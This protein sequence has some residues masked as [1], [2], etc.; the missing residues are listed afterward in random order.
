MSG[1]SRH[2]CVTRRKRSHQDVSLFR[3]KPGD[4]LARKPKIGAWSGSS[5]QRTPGA[6]DSSSHAAEVDTNASACYA[7]WGEALLDEHLLLQIAPAVNSS[8]G[9]IMVAPFDRFGGALTKL[10]QS[11]Q[12]RGFI[13]ELAKTTGLAEDKVTSVIAELGLN[14][15]HSFPAF[16]T[17][18]G[19]AHGAQLSAPEVLQARAVVRV[20]RSI[21][22]C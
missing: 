10:S 2:R 16:A 20:G 22:V 1:L 18:S 3:Q 12:S 7:G 8:G 17:E 21:I 9:A 13:S 19:S 11:A 14:E 15:V 5:L 6:N 4:R